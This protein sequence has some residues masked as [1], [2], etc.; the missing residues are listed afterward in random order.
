MLGDQPRDVV[1]TAPSAWLAH[2]FD[3]RR[4]TSERIS[5]SL[6][7]AWAVPSLRPTEPH[8]DCWPCKLRSTIL[9]SDLML[10]SNR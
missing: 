9:Q 6:I 4:G 7:S 3:R 1:A 5:G 2:D 8:Q 10:I